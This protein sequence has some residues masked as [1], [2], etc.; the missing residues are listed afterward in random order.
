MLLVYSGTDSPR[1]KYIVHTLL[2]DIAGIPIS[3]THDREAYLSFEGPSLNYSPERIRAEE[4]QVVPCGLLDEEGVR[5]RDLP[6]FAYQGY[7][8][9]FPVSGGDMDFDVF[10]ASFWLLSRY[11]EYLP[12][13][14]DGYGRF[15]HTHSLAWKEGFLHLPLVSIWAD[16]LRSALVHRFPGLEPKPRQ[17]RFIPT[18][19][20]DIAFSYLHK[21]WVRTAGGISRS[22]LKAQ[23]RELRERF[24]VLRG[25][26]R[27]PYDV[28][29]WLDARHLA[30]GLK[31]WYFF[32]L[33][34]ERRGVD[35]NIHPSERTLRELVS[36]HAM[37]YP[38]GL[39]PSW[40]SGD[41]EELLERELRTL[42]SMAGRKVNASRQ[43][44]IRFTLPG[45]YRRLITAGIEKDFSM[46]YGT[47]NGF[48]ASV[49]APF[50][51]YDLDK[52]EE[53]TLR[54]FPFC[55]MDANSVFE[56][57]DTPAHAFDELS[58]Y[59]QL[60]KKLRGTM[61]TVWHNNILGD[62][63]RFPGWRE[64]YEVFLRDVVYWDI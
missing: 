55:F 38:V 50:A 20:I 14:L 19:D 35:R 24:A 11:E 53:T 29:E 7:P 6:I 33:A 44:Y 26:R 60:V 30:Y 4:W 37:G 41:R 17:F 45:T 47:I 22:L 32:L 42:E 10:S 31:P 23:W 43:H 51:W 58:R 39:H 5:G 48:R 3:V 59:H 1:W 40:Q 8:C 56:Q 18:Y 27:D 13:P 62:D 49:A 52:D 9:F 28:Y 16:A 61:I 2:G 54:I 63:P 25:E 15:D 34:E 12:H 57:K 36:Y 21:G 64:V 46:G